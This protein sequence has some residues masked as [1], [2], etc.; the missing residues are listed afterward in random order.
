MVDSRIDMKKHSELKP[1]LADREKE[2]AKSLNEQDPAKVAAI[3]KR[4]E[5]MDKEIVK[6]AEEIIKI[7]FPAATNVK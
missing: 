7:D 2:V 5:S 6:L 4:V 1:H 3:K